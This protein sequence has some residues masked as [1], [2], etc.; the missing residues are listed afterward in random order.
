MHA[1]A[2]TSTAL[3]AASSPPAPLAALAFSGCGGLHVVL[4][5]HSTLILRERVQWRLRGQLAIGQ[6]PKM[7]LRPLLLTAATVT[8]TAKEGLL[9]PLLSSFCVVSH[10]FS[11]IVAEASLRGAEKPGG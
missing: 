11:S 7:T 5:G 6:Q 8:V 9:A 1:R 10:S 3:F 2:H 4:H